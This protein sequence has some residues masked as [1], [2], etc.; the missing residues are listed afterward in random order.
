MMVLR[1]CRDV[2]VDQDGV[3]TKSASAAAV[4]I[5]VLTPEGHRGIDERNVVA[6]QPELGATLGRCRWPVDHDEDT[7]SP[8]LD[9]RWYG[10]EQR[11]II[12]RMGLLGAND[13]C[14]SAIAQER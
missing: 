11:A 14:S 13:S 6:P 4:V 10:Y 7:V 8:R 1:R 12:A 9:V 5:D 2:G 3:S